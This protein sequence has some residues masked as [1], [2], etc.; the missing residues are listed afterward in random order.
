V[1]II[2]SLAVS[3]A[4][5]WLGISKNNQRVTN[6]GDDFDIRNYPVVAGKKAYRDFCGEFLAMRTK[7]N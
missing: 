7:L 5:K 1:P 6:R 4:N 3:A 2:K